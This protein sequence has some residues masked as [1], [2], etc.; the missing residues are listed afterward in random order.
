MGSSH[1]ETYNAIREVLF[2]DLSSAGIDSVKEKRGL[3]LRRPDPAQNEGDD[4][5]DEFGG[6][7]QV[8]ADEN[9]LAGGFAD[10]TQEDKLRRPGDIFIENLLGYGP[11]CLD[12]AV[13]SGLQEANIEGSIDNAVYVVQ[14]SVWNRR[15]WKL[16][17]AASDQRFP[18]S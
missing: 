7:T 4:G 3:V 9:G 18:G 14:A 2:T 16:T 6:G 1:Q 13:T 8:V 17:Q 15:F 12:L 5:T 10:S 11:T